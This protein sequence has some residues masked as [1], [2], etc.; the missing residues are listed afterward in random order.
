MFYQ[1]CIQTP[2][3][4]SGLLFDFLSSF[5]CQILVLESFIKSS[6]NRHFGSYCIKVSSGTLLSKYD[7]ET[8][9]P[10]GI[11][12]SCILLSEY[13]SQIEVRL[14]H[15][16]CECSNF[17]PILP[18]KVA[19]RSIL[20]NISLSLARQHSPDTRAMSYSIF[21]GFLVLQEFPIG[22]CFLLTVS[23]KLR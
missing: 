12:L 6:T 21:F 1:H 17:H 9:Y 8:S 4:L 15:N 16:L 7:W 14:R 2:F 3:T 19:F 18:G 13:P 22:W 23:A 5:F 11:E 10:S 20:E